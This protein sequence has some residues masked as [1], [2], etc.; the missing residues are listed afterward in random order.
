MQRS[1]PRDVVRQLSEH[2]NRHQQDLSNRDFT[3]CIILGALKDFLALKIETR[4]FR[5]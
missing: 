3:I 4:L 1:E 2:E 5:Q